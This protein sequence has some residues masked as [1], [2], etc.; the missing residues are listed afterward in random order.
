MHIYLVESPLQ[1]ISAVEAINYFRHGR[2]LII[3]RLAKDR[4]E[5]NEQFR[6]VVNSL[7][8][9]KVIFLD[10]YTSRYV[11]ILGRIF[12]YIFLRVFSC[13]IDSISIGEWRS[14]WMHRCIEISRKC[15]ATLLDDGLSTRTSLINNIN[16]GFHNKLQISSADTGL[17]NGIVERS[18]RLI[19]SRRSSHYN[20]SVFSTCCSQNDSTTVS[21]ISHNFES[22]SRRLVPSMTEDILYF[23]SKLSEAG[24]LT[25]EDEVT[26]LQVIF[27]RLSDLFPTKRIYYIPHRDESDQKLLMI[28]QTGFNIKKLGLPAEVYFILNPKLPCVIASMYS[29]SI[30]NLSKIFTFRRVLFFRIPEFYLSKE[31]LEVLRD[32]YKFFVNE[33]YEVLDLGD[34]GSNY[35]V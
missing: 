7:L 12:L 17:W 3:A 16:L 4:T 5:N 24:L 29:A 27:N 9:P 8:I 34:G 25:N 11:N 31:R 15:K 35:E 33:S 28:K 1:L 21:V 26:L 20:F 13:K 22:L 6:K 2:V 32:L 23:G 18:F 19:G 30:Y 14:T 10:S